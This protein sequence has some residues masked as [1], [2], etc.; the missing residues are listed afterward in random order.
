MKENKTY[1]FETD[2]LLGRGKVLQAYRKSDFAYIE[3]IVA[4]K[5]KII[6]HKIKDQKINT[7]FDISKFYAKES[8]CGFQQNIRKLFSY[9]FSKRCY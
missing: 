6:S 1:F 9:S 8:L 2:E 7:Y 5:L 3:K 4:K